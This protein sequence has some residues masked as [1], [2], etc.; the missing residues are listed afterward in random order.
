MQLFKVG[1]KSNFKEV[2][3]KVKMAFPELLH[4]NAHEIS[5]DLWE[6]KNLY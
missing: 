5:I 4:R 1:I 6:Q 3:A 2:Y